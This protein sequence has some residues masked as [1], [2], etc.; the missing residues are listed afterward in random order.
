MKKKLA[1][2]LSI[3]LATLPISGLSVL[4]DTPTGTGTTAVVS[5]TTTGTDSTSTAATST[6]S[7]A[8]ATTA[9]GSTGNTTPGTAGTSPAGDQTVSGTTDAAASPVDENGQPVA[10]GISPDSPF[11]WLAQLINK[12]QVALTFDPA[13]KADLLQHQALKNLASAQKAEADG[14][15][16]ACQKALDAYSDKITAAQNFLDQVKDPASESFQTLAKALSNVNANNVQ[17]LGNV[18]S[19]LPPQAAEK[20][21][22][23]V[24]R[25]M[26]KAEDRYTKQQ[27]EQLDQQ[28]AAALK[29]FE[30]SLAKKGV[31]GVRVAGNENVTVRGS[32]AQTAQDAEVAQVAQVAQDD[33]VS[34]L[35]GEHQNPGAEHKAQLAK[36][37]EK[38]QQGAGQRA[39]KQDDERDGGKDGD[40][41]A[42]VKS[43]QSRTVDAQVANQVQINEQEAK[44]HGKGSRNG[45]K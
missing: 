4:A 3:A 8:T 26:K 1:L 30:E 5:T 16:E 24:V 22:L 20:V 7:S 34:Q 11:Y 28:A 12:L 21:A 25:A 38:G 33:Q 13:K 9:T 2:A 10:P 29:T 31:K 37:R 17:V 43:Q 18:I 40:Q 36:D 19:K 35:N 39:G 14:K 42:V 6:D 41:G 23:N 45:R 44:E 15:K 27:N 32:D